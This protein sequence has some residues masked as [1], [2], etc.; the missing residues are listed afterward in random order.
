MA[1]PYKRILVATDFSPSAQRAL[2]EALR[3]AD[4]DAELTLIH[5]TPKLEPALPWSRTN[6]RIVTRL[7]RQ[8]VADAR[9]ALATLAAGLD[10]VRP[11]TRVRIGVA[12]EAILDEAK[13]RRAQV[14]VIG[15]Q[16]HTLS[17]RLTIGSTAERVVRKAPIPVL[18]T[19]TKR[20]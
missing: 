7:G 2:R 5:V 9:T 20:R 16:G 13:R 3:L 10:G 18:V 11:H 19:P 14:I 17:E 4:D 8:A 15:S 6:R 12:H 1:G